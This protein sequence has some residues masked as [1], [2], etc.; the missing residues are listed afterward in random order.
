MTMHVS[1][2]GTLYLC[3][4]TKRIQCADTCDE[5]IN[6]HVAEHYRNIVILSALKPFDG[7][8]I[9]KSMLR[10]DVDEDKKERVRPPKYHTDAS[11]R[12]AR[13]KD[14]SEY[15]HRGMIRSAR[16]AMSSGDERGEGVQSDADAEEV[17][18]MKN[19]KQTRDKVKDAQE[20]YMELRKMHEELTK[21]MAEHEAFIKES[22]ADVD[23]G[24]GVRK[25]GVRTYMPC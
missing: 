2:T 25:R 13:Y 11:K 12:N 14:A 7:Q 15:K 5:F 20:K 1:L 10:I 22:A 6:E 4:Q 18:D 21:K 8:R 3:P 17:M 16:D 9:E 19:E 23:V 24:T